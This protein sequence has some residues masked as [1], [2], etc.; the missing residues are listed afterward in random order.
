[1]EIGGLEHALLVDYIAYLIN[2][3]MAATRLLYPG[4]SPD[5]VPL[6]AIV[7]FPPSTSIA[8]ARLVMT[9]LA[10]SDYAPRPFKIKPI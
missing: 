2:E 4:S 9:F 6:S 5:F 1:M 10:G 7:S 8:R 3:R